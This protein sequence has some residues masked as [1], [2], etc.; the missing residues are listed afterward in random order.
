MD[1]SE[2]QRELKAIITDASP[3]I[4]LSIPDIINETYKLAI[5]K[6]G[7]QGLKTTYSLTTSTTLAYTVFPST[8]SGKFTYVGNAE[9]P[10]QVYN[11]LE[12]MAVDYPVLD[13]VGAVESTAV[14][15]QLLWYQPIPATAETITV[16]GY[17][18]P[19]D[20]V[21]DTDTTTYLPDFLHRGIIV[22]GAAASVFNLIEDGMDGAKANTKHYLGLAMQA[23]AELES[24]LVRRNRHFTKRTGYI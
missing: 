11:S 19:A 15:N 9:G 17:A 5:D 2:M 16:I 10:L 4:L 22:Y 6:I 12:D 21:N 18:T 23:W 1:F 8:F 24:Y 3:A 14:E 7:V 20:L 13:E